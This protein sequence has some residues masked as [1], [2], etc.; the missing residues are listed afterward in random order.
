MIPLLGWDKAEVVN[1]N[2]LHP[3]ANES[4]VINLSHNLVPEN[5]N[6]K[7]FATAMLWK[8]IRR[9]MEKERLISMNKIEYSNTA[10]TVSIS[11]NN[12]EQKLVKY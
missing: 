5:D 12:G 10:N 7:V 9:K 3:V 1:S 2:G 11:L 8:K 4:V 6:T